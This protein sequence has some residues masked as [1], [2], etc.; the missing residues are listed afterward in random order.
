MRTIYLHV[1]LFMILISYSNIYSQRFNGGIHAGV[2]ATQVSGDEQAGFNKAGIYGGGFVNIYFSQ[3]SS[4]QMEL[5]FIQKGSRKNPKPDNG[6][7][8]KYVCRL[9]YIEM[10]LMYKLDVTKW[11]TLEIGAA[12]AYLVKSSEEDENGSV[13]PYLQFKKYEISLIGGGYYN[14]SKHFM[15]NVRYENTF[16]FLP[17]RQHASRASY[18]LNKGQYNSVLIFALQYQFK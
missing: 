10:P 7:Y 15:V 12:A 4:V 9:N 6:D 13:S 8:T 18:N 5:N 16:P 17:I 3:R 11:L 2:S 14:F 1:V